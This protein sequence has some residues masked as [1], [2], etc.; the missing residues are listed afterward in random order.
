MEDINIKWGKM[1][2]FYDEILA[3]ESFYD[4]ILAMESF[5]DEILAME[6]IFTNDSRAFYS[7]T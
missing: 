3:M 1:E 4:E 7:V 2:S 6:A 5:Y